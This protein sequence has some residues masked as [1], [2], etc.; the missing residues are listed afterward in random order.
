MITNIFKIN[1]KQGYKPMWHNFHDKTY[2]HKK[3]K[4]WQVFNIVTCYDFAGG[5]SG[6]GIIYKVYCVRFFSFELTRI[7][8]PK[9]A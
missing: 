3:A 7:A 6:G 5:L 8:I 9:Y 1:L 4:L 2:K